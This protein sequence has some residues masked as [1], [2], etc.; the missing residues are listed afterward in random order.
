MGG[1]PDSDLAKPRPGPLTGKVSGTRTFSSTQRPPSKIEGCETNP[2]T[3]SKYLPGLRSRSSTRSTWA[4]ACPSSDW[5]APF[6]VAVM[7]LSLLCLPAALQAQPAEQ[8]PTDAAGKPEPNTTPLRIGAGVALIVIIG[9]IV[10]RRKG[11][12]KKADEDF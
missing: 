9:I 3:P 6:P 4:A 1:A 5:Y 2:T 8:A 10:L 7:S 11:K 12:A